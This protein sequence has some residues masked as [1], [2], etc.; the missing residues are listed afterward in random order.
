MLKRLI[1]VLHPGGPANEEGL[2]EDLNL[3]RFLTQ[4]MSLICQKAKVG[5]ITW[6]DG[7]EM[8]HIAPL[9]NGHQYEK[10]ASLVADLLIK[11]THDMTV[12]QLS[13]DLAGFDLNLS[14]TQVQ[15]TRALVLVNSPLD[16]RV[17]GC[18]LLCDP[19]E[20]IQ[21]AARVA[22][23]ITGRY[24]RHLS[25]CLEH[26]RVLNQSYTDDLTGLNN[27]KYMTLVLENEIHRAS[28][29]SSKFS[30]M[31]MDIDFFK[32][33]N[34]SKGHWVGS[35]LLVELARILKSSTRRSDYLFRYGGDEFVIVLPDTPQKGAVVAAERIRRKVEGTEFLIDGHQMKLTVSVGIATYPD[36][37]ESCKDIIKMADQAMYSGKSKS[38]NVVIMAS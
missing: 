14:L 38:R 35:R 16:Q 37:A 32:S 27:Q 4:S 2:C 18:Y 10:A 29:N 1:S 34:D 11:T 22:S 3:Q 20:D 12:E 21:T 23:Q 25:F 19:Q 9:L 26:Q 28:R 24:A 31:F 5:R 6:I 30:I 33:V 17:L 7:Q 36:H 15:G 13:Q 8:P